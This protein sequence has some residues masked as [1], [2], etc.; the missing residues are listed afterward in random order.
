[1]ADTF[2][3]DVVIEPLMEA[4]KEHAGAILEAPTGAGKST[5]VPIALLQSEW[6]SLGRIIMLE[7]R[8]VA[9]RS[10]AAFMAGQLGEKPGETIGYRTRTDTKIGPET[11]LEVVTEGVLAR[12]LLAD[13]TLEGVSLVIFDEFH[14]RSL[15]G[16]LSLALICE[17]REAFREDL[18]MVIMSAT[19]DCG[20]LTER[21]AL[22]LIRSEG[23]SYPVDVSYSPVR[24]GKDW[25]THVAEM[26]LEV[27][28]QARVI[29]VF[30]PGQSAIRRVSQY[31]ISRTVSGAVVELHGGLALEKQQD[32]IALAAQGNPLIILAT[33][34]AETS[35]TI[36][37]VTHVVDSGLCREPVYDPARHRSRLL[38]RRISE[39]SARQ[40]AGRAGRLG[41][42]ICIRCWSEDEV[43]A[44]HLTPEIN[45]VGLDQLVLDL[46]RWGCLD[47]AQMCWL[48]PPPHS[49]WRSA[50]TRLEGLGALD[51][52]GRIT[53]R[54]ESIAQ[55]AVEPA[56]A[57]LVLAGIEAN[58]GKTAARIAALLSDR[59]IL[60]GG[61]ADLR[62]R[63]EALENEPVRYRKVLEE[64]GRIVQGADTGFE[65]WREG[66]E[67]LI[68]SSMPMQLAR[69]RSGQFRRYQM[70]D[71]PG[72]ILAD[73]DALT[74]QEWLLVLDTDGEPR[75]AR[76]RLALVIKAETI[77]A[78]TPTLAK[79]RELVEWDAKR[80]R[81][82]GRRIVSIGQIEL[83]S[84][85]LARLDPE[86][87]AEGLLTGVRNE[88]LE[89]LPWTPKLRQWQARVARMR[90]L[91]S[92]W[93]DVSDA[94]LSSS[95]EHWL[96]PYLSGMRT[97]NDL[98]GVAL[99][100]ALAGF[101]D[102]SQHQVL[103][104]L[105]PDS[106]R[107]PT[108]RMVPLDYTGEHVVLAVKLQELFGLSALPE[109][110]GGRLKIT[111][112]LLTPA[113]RPAAITDNL[114]RFWS[115]NYEA[116]RKELR[117]RYPKHPWPEDPLNAVA[118]ALTKKRAGQ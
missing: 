30:L 79:T 54:G 69:L 40:R 58:L 111:A 17:T 15:Q 24:Q 44:H 41:P 57:S 116:V 96:L 102:Q 112:H 109:L 65:Q 7:P 70:A 86:Q 1:M 42:G 73:H 92:D 85:P 95:L 52:A 46:A 10:V 31:L 48:D 108:G 75:D 8:R 115:E 32:V 29:L 71:G 18:G 107:I 114:A 88:G 12:M 33:N 72:V 51:G 89:P 36:E 103:D 82:I 74:G 49:S 118:T 93:P 100:S 37:N 106:V 61:G 3:V 94:A 9:A 27:E 98:K 38:T 80:Q 83:Q 113:G 77:E 104:R 43:M 11:R 64:A 16:D 56:L 60:P 35:L 39:A 91:E 97:V 117:G 99:E 14:E 34:V 23:R 19:L 20:P 68:A 22:P 62:T 25:E 110:A 26:I 67:Q 28:D 76:I 59:D 63:L 5:R 105:M 87:V 55:L 2:P 90:L 47:P 4:L 13:P 78:L 84:Q 53:P 21:L 45:R 50:V 6:G 66:L 101:L 81:V